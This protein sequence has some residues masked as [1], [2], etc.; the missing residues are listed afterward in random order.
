MNTVME[1]IGLVNHYK[2]FRFHFIFVSN[3]TD[4][5]NLQAHCHYVNLGLN[6]ISA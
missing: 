6:Q 5:P 3:L 2:N 1:I 4:A